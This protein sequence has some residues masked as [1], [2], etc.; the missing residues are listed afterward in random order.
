MLVVGVAF[1][2]NMINA[3]GSLQVTEPC[4]HGGRGR[5][6][7][8]NPPISYQLPVALKGEGEQHPHNS[9]LLYTV[10]SYIS[11]RQLF[12]FSIIFHKSFLS[13]RPSRPSIRF[14][15]G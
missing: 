8:I 15:N 5:H 10:Y 13:E 4:C 9:S 7:F 2:C 3:I 14:A 12:L 6:C 11:Y 1:A